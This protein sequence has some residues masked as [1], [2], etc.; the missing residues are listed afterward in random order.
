[1]LWASVMAHASWGAF[2]AL[3]FILYYINGDGKWKV[4]FEA[5]IGLGG[6]SGIILI[7]DRI[8]PIEDDIIRMYSIGS[9]FLAFLL[10]TGILMIVVS[11][12]IKDNDGRDIIRLRDILL[13]QYSFINDYYKKR[14]TEIDDKL[15]IPKL[16][17]REV[18]ISHREK[19]LEA[20]KK[21]ISDELEKLE[22]LGARKL[23]LKLPENKDITLNREYIETMP[24]YIADTFTCISDI[25]SCTQSL[26][27]KPKE[28][29]NISALK[30]YFISIATYISSDLFGGTTTDARIHF[31]VYDKNTDGYVKFVAVMGSKLVT[32]DMTVIPYSD[33]SMIKKSFECKRALIKSI[34][35]TH[36]FQSNNHNLWQD[37]MTYTFYGMTY[38]NKPYLSFGISVKNAERYKKAL[39][40]INYFRLE[41]FLQDN[42]E[43]INDAVDIASILYGGSDNV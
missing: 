9:C 16:E 2:L 17:A 43:R 33:D 15:S 42:I 28:S 21:Y 38:E 3:F 40:F 30:S 18:A 12:L 23:K 8:I 14:S 4:L 5:I 26:L 31:R 41:S 10:T 34:N 36:D 39:H 7:L 19:E 35:C 20:E 6:N 25:N 1:M 37:Y 24:S 27:A 22:E 32:N 11:F 13:G 29:V